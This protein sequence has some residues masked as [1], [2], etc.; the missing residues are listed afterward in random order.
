M[1]KD[2]PA[3]EREEPTGPPQDNDDRILRM[4]SRLR[5]HSPLARQELEDRE[6][7]QASEMPKPATPL[8]SSPKVAA[9]PST[10]LESSTA[11]DK[12]KVAGEETPSAA[13]MKVDKT[14]KEPAPS[15]SNVVAQTTPE[16]KASRKGRAS[17]D[18]RPDLAHVG[19]I[20]GTVS[21]G[22]R[23]IGSERIEGAK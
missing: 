18:E 20:V 1:Q 19:P 13:D 12:K 15:S 4:L 22:A 17:G 5:E 8:S 3:V 2:A 23:R 21:A 14:K 10:P 11:L 16:A 6:S 9:V 7:K